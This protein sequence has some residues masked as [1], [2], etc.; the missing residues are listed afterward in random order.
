MP[1]ALS[2]HLRGIGA[3][4]LIAH[5]PD[6]NTSLNPA[7]AWRVAYRLPG[8]PAVH[9]LEWPAHASHPPAER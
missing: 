8:D 4:V 2:A 3:R 7:Y 6:T 9:R 5:H 1:P